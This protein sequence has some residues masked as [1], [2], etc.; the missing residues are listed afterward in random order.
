MGLK[1]LFNH[2]TKEEKCSLRAKLKP[3]SK[4]TSKTKLLCWVFSGHCYSDVW[5]ICSCINRDTI[6]LASISAGRWSVPTFC[7]VFSLP[8]RKTKHH[9]KSLEKICMPNVYTWIIISILIIQNEHRK[10]WKVHRIN[11]GLQMSTWECKN[12]T[13]DQRENGFTS[14]SRR[15]RNT[16]VYLRGVKGFGLKRP[17]WC[18]EGRALTVSFMAFSGA[19]PRSCGTRPIIRIQVD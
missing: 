8:R 3:Q 16:G 15:E 9:W 1:W 6:N 7:I 18:G 13:E 5:I 17:R 12:V 4:L 10:M 14:F 2:P 19:T 11:V